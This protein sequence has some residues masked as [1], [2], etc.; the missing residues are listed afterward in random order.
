[1]TIFHGFVMSRTLFVIAA[2][3]SNRGTNPAADGTANDGAIAPSEFIP[4]CCTS[5]S[6]KS[7][8]DGRIEGGVVRM[9]N[10]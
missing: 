2:V 9:G 8:T 10:G 1:M 5:G 7:A 3:C 4:N 6:T